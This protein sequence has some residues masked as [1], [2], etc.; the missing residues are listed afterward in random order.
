MTPFSNPLAD[1]PMLTDNTLST[2]LAAHTI[3]P[4]V[5]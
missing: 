2:T 5:I 1:H 3:E 4:L